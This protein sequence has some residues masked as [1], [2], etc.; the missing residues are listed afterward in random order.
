MLIINKRAGGR[1]RCAIT[2]QVDGAWFFQITR[3]YE[4]GI[5]TDEWVPLPNW[6]HGLIFIPN[7]AGDIDESYLKDLIQSHYGRKAAQR[8]NRPNVTTLYH[9]FNERRARDLENKTV[10]AMS[11]ETPRG[12]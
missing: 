9:E 4:D 6:K 1:I 8:L 12:N 5:V 2:N 3:D 7:I 10:F 11:K